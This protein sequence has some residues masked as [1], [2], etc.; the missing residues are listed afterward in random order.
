M[1]CRLP[2][3][4]MAECL[5]ELVRSPG[6]LEVWRCRRCGQIQIRRRMAV[7]GLR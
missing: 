6:L 7:G 5:L 2:T 4:F 3:V 1:K